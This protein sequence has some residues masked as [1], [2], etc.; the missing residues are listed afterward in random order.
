[1]S[2]YDKDYFENGPQT[3]KSLYTNYRWLPEVTIPIAHH[4]ATYLGLKPQDKILD[5]GCSKGYTVKALRLLGLDAY[6]VDISDYAMSQIDE[7]TRPYCKLISD[8]EYP[9]GF[10][11]GTLITKDVLEHLSKEQLVSFLNNYGKHVDTM[12][13]I[14]PLGDSGVYRLSEAHLDPTHVVAEDEFWWKD[15]FESCGFEVLDIRHTIFGVKDNWLVK[16]PKGIGFFKI[17][18]KNK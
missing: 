9:F 16:N 14:M 1:M 17:S 12:L 5:F 11:I 18:R 3:G 2:Q 8:L 10:D 7:H 15:L 13:H 6:G 4:L